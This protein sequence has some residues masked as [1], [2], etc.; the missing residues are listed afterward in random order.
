[1]RTRIPHWGNIRIKVSAKSASNGYFYRASQFVH[2]L[3]GESHDHSALGD[4]YHGCHAAFFRNFLF[5][6][7]CHCLPEGFS[8]PYRIWCCW[9]MFLKLGVFGVPGFQYTVT[10]ISL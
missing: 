4:L 1:M 7:T 3:V 10:S 9:Y 5:F 8:P 6:L 2:K